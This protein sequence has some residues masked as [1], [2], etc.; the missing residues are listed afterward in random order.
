MLTPEQREKR[1]AYYYI[2]KAECQ[3][4]MR[5]YR[6]EHAEEIRHHKKADY[7]ANRQRV[8]D[9]VHTYREANVE[10]IR[11]KALA[12]Q[13]TLDG[14]ILHCM[15]TRVLKAMRGRKQA[16]PTMALVGCD[17]ARLKD[18]LESNFRGGMSWDNYGFRGWHIDHIRPC[19]SFDLAD[20]DQQRA[21][22]H[23]SNLQPL[24]ATENLT[25]KKREMRELA[26]QAVT[27]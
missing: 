20:P 21:C 13:A 26:R 15:R 12:R 1:R 11:A 16:A 23:W 4:R 22:F 17:L 25:K 3:A 19:A 2:N 27:A 6:E 8:L 9:R 7:E 10:T 18:H 24:W 5:R 14:R